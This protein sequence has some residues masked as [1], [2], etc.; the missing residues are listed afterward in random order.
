MELILAYICIPFI[1]TYNFS[2]GSKLY[3]LVWA[4]FC[5]FALLTREEKREKEKHSLS[6]I[7]L[8]NILAELP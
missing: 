2:I 7:G 1:K 5:L 4:C 8:I 6:K 3:C